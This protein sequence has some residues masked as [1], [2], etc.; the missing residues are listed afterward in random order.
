M[1]ACDLAPRADGSSAS[2]STYS[3][4]GT[5][6]ASS[7]VVV[8]STSLSGDASL[9]SAPSPIVIQNLEYNDALN[10]LK[11]KTLA[12]LSKLLCSSPLSSLRQWCTDT[13]V[14][15]VGDLRGKVSRSLPLAQKLLASY[16]LYANLSLDSLRLVARKTG[17]RATTRD[18]LIYDALR[19]IFPVDLLRKILYVCN[20][21]A[22][23]AK[24]TMYATE[25][26]ARREAVLSKVRSLVDSWPPRLE[27]EFLLRCCA[28]Y[29]KATTIRPPASCASCGRSFL[30]DHLTNMFV[31]SF[32]QEHLLDSHPLWVLKADE[33]LAPSFRA[34]PT[35]PSRLLDGLMLFHSYAVVDYTQRE[36]LLR[37]CLDCESAFNSRKTPRFSLRNNLFRGRLPLEF[38]D[39]TWIEEK[40]CA[41]HRVTADIARLHHAENDEKLPFRLVG[42]ICAYPAN[43]ASTA[44]VLPRVPADIN[45]HLTV[46]FVGHNFDKKKLP[47]MF[48]VRRRI[49]EG[50]LRFLAASNPLYKEVQISEENLALYPEDDVLPMLAESVIISPP[51]M[52]TDQLLQESASFEGHPAVLLSRSTLDP[53]GPSN[54]TT[55][56][57]CAPPVLIETTGVV[58]FSGSSINGHSSIANAI[59]NLLRP[60]HE[61]DP[62]DLILPRRRDPIGKYDNPDLLPGMF[63]TLFP[64]GSGGLEAERPKAED[65]D[66][67]PARKKRKLDSPV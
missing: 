61:G 14:V 37:M 6:R 52:Q 49:I 31:F 4:P 3:T 50:F 38:H 43:V 51:S 34:P 63:P 16:T 58:D 53:P 17:S 64:C 67:Q 18:G 7:P 2:S 12:E 48:R 35:F 20:I 40:V 33:R 55:E 8:A 19:S 26:D 30:A 32:E 65:E 54:H 36:F 27:D 24:R 13:S 10:L 23:A 22:K 25:V 57:D 62:P 29:V 56:D 41:L 59:Y 60:R 66:D 15:P 39:M 1:S 28:D 21:N 9:L 5:S 42:N 47:A 46:V 11:R 45:G 44:R